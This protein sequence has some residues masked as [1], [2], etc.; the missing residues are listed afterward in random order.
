MGRKQKLEA[1][2]AACYKDVNA[3]ADVTEFVE[4]VEQPVVS[5]TLDTAI[6]FRLKARDYVEKEALP[7][8]EYLTDKSV[9]AFLEGLWK[10]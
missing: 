2:R 8:C 1:A 9:V 7:L 3:E 4:V 10:K 6:E 5:T